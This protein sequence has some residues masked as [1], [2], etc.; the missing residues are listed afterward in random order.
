MSGSHIHSSEN[1]CK[2]KQNTLKITN[3]INIKKD[4][5]MLIASPPTEAK[6]TDLLFTF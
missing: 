4:K 2:V 5:I 6:T 3:A 1:L